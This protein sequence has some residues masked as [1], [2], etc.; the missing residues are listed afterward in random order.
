M[1]FSSLLDVATVA[2]PGANILLPRPDF[3]LYELCVSFRGVEVRHYRRTQPKNLSSSYPL[4]K[5]FL[6]L[7][8]GY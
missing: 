2:R 3:S 7:V 1:M 5:S 4:K 6:F 8:F